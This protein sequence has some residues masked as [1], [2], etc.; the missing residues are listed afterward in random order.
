MNWDTLF[1]GGV[2]PFNVVD[3][4]STAVDLRLTIRCSS[5]WAHN[6]YPNIELQICSSDDVKIEFLITESRSVP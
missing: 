6:N 3:L 4:L 5:K 1:G 2:P